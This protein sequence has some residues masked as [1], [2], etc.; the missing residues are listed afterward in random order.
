MT[1]VIK[2]ILFHY[3]FWIYYERIRYTY[4]DNSSSSIIRKIKTFGNFT[5]TNCKYYGTL[6]AL[7]ILIKCRNNKFIMRTFSWLLINSFN[8]FK[9][10]DYFFSFPEFIM[11]LQHIV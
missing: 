1:F 7:N 8:L 5:S 3:G 2:I 10:F 6:T 9:F 11:A 4:K